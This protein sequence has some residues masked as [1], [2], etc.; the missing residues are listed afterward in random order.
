MTYRLSNNSPPSGSSLGDGLVE[1]IV[2]QQVF[3]LLVLV[4]SLGDIGQEDR[5]DD[6]STW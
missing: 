4:E 3:K 2:K 6:T 1:E 5:L